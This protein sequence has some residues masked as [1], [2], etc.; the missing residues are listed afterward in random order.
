MKDKQTEIEDNSK[1]K[2][3]KKHKFRFW[4]TLIITICVFVLLISVAQYVLYYFAFPLL[5][6]KICESVHK[7]TNGLYQM[8]FDDIKLNILTTSIS[9]TNFTLKPDTTV[10]LKLKDENNYNRAIY[11][12]SVSDFEINNIKLKSIFGS[13]ELGINNIFMKNPVIRLAG[14]PDEKSKGKYDA[15]HK[16]LYPLISKYFGSVSVNDIEITN[17]YFDFYKKITDDKEMAMV[18]NINISMFNF[19]MNELIYAVNNKFLYSDKIYLNSNDYKIRLADSTHSISTGSL[20]IN[21]ED[22]TI[23]ASKVSLLADGKKANYTNKEK[24]N[25]N[26]DTILIKGV[27]INKAYFKGEV[28]ISDVKLTNPKIDF[29]TGKK[30]NK[31]SKKLE[32]T[33][34]GNWY[35]LIKGTLKSINIDTFNISN[36]SIKIY[37]IKFTKPAYEIGKLDIVLCGFV[38]DSLA[39]RS[40]S[41]I[42]Y[43]NDLDINIK[44]FDMR[45]PDHVHLLSSNN[46]LVSTRNKIITANNIKI[47]PLFNSHDSTD[48][49]MNISVP[50]LDIKNVDIKKAYNSQNYQ[51]SSVAIVLPQIESRSFHDTASISKPKRSMIK[52]LAD[53]YFK[54]L[55]INRLSIIKGEVDI[56]Q[57][58]SI[59]EDSLTLIGKLS[60]SIDNFLI[61]QQSI[62]ENNRTFLCSNISFSLNDFVMKP[63]KSLHTLR[64]NSLNIDSKQK[65]ISLNNL[66][67]S[68]DMDADFIPNLKR[69]GKHSVMALK[70][71]NA[72]IDNT[73]LIEGLYNHKIDIG[74]INVSCPEFVFYEYPDFKIKNSSNKD[75][76]LTDSI[77]DTNIPTDK[78]I[79]Q[80]SIFN[81]RSNLEKLV[82]NCF[83][84]NINL[85]KVDSLNIDSGIVKVS[86]RD[87]FNVSKIETE[88][89]FK[90]SI[91]KFNYNKDSIYNENKIL[92]ADNYL[93]NINNFRFLLPDGIHAIKAGEISISTLGKYF[94]AKNVF[95]SQRDEFE[96]VNHNIINSYYPEIEITGVDFEKFN[97]TGSLNADICNMNNGVFTITKADSVAKKDENKNGNIINNI[98]KSIN[99]F[100]INSNNNKFGIYENH[101]GL[102]SRIVYADFDFSCDSLLVDSCNFAQNKH[103][104]TF[105]N[106]NFNISNFS[107]SL[108]DGDNYITTN[109]ATLINDTIIVDNFYF[110]NENTKHG[111]NNLYIP[112]ITITKP[113]IEEL[114]FG[115]AIKVENIFINS[116]EIEASV[117]K[118]FKKQNK[119]KFSFN[120]IF[121]KFNYIIADTI[122]ADSINLDIQR[123]NKNNIKL[124]NL[125]FNI[126]ALNT[127]KYKNIEY[128]L[129]QIN[130]GVNHYTTYL[131][132]SLFMLYLKRI[133]F[134]PNNNNIIIYNSEYRPTAN[135]YNFYKKFEFRKS[136]TYLACDK[137]VAHNFDIKKFISNKEININ[138]LDINKL[139]LLSYLNKKTP[140]DTSD[141]KPNLHQQIRN[142]PIPITIDSAYIKNSFIEIEQLSPEASVPG[143][144]TIN[145]IS[146]EIYNFTNN[147]NDIKNNNTLYFVGRGKLMNKS[148]IQ[149]S[150]KYILDSKND[151]FICKANVDTIFLP[152]LNPYLEN[153][154]F[155]KINDGTLHSANIE[156]SA[157][158]KNSSGESIFKYSGLKLSVNKKDSVQT[159]RRGLI[160]WLANS[161]IR[162]DNPKHKFSRVKKGYI[163]ATPDFN[164]GFT[165]YW[166]KSMLSGA[167]ATAGFESKEQKD[168]RKF[169]EKIKSVIKRN[170]KKD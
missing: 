68:A 120:N 80:D 96:I 25:V 29:K 78:E 15:V 118:Q 149:A 26:L 108:K 94:K 138:R 27:D 105:C 95:M 16:D 151:E 128:P 63:S 46:L 73:L 119:Q 71:K 123:N 97:Q 170:E 56:D 93:L 92:F 122:K 50:Q 82:A 91:N 115:K 42:L 99:I 30:R 60:M 136:A 166:I 18:G 121:H 129:Q 125:D 106:P 133:E 102:T 65:K 76:I 36:A 53:E 1:V 47:K 164:K 161:I 52:A 7:N 163:Y 111:L 155:A 89:K 150:F 58:S 14:K 55:N 168:K 21:T 148:N 109:K 84:K 130:I 64:G 40:K 39:Y 48:T 34:S 112:K 45:L 37:N 9:L 143:V 77:A 87:S 114:A 5:K 116:P 132:D 156:F 141:I 79:Y 8:N 74:N 75:S 66:S 98:I 127:Q 57:Q 19:N 11:N 23:L 139:S 38:L 35:S 17:G 61:T 44:D 107:A 54:S 62:S 169:Y 22:S 144:L 33:G 13:R 2:I 135:K 140:I 167:K 147:Y 31:E 110:E 86:I 153:A 146:G 101:R 124:K 154:M 90:F 158:N 117:N 100:K 131:K 162:T 43:S 157:N 134:E 32:S 12:V 85:I 88:N 145:D 4:K 20:I 126:I 81:L 51:M 160:S 70:I 24:F 67:Y 137:L 113:D 103:I 49:R 152:I 104:A 165:S 59:L 72:E 6:E 83:P 28:D 142:I 69:L 41:K 159:K 3:E 10:Y